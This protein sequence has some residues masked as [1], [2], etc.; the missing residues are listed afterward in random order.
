MRSLTIQWL[1][2]C[3]AA[4]EPAGWLARWNFDPLLLAALAVVSLYGVAKLRG[5]V[6]R[7]RVFGAAVL[8]LVVLFVSPLCALTSALFAARTV[9]H[10]ALV[11]FAAPL[12][13]WALPPRRIPTANL[14]AWTA[15]HAAIFWAWH[16][17]AF[18][19]AA[20]SSDAVYW[21]MQSSL[22]GSAVM[23]WAGVR[24]SAVTSAVAALLANM[25]QMGLLGALLT[26]ASAPLYAPHLATTR[27][28]GFAAIEDQ[29]LAGLVMWAPGAALYLG[30][31]LLVANRWLSAESRLAA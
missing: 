28:W 23:F 6:R 12:L 19:G 5:D 15:G 31:A 2:Y 27:A 3:G 20:L 16:W 30:A 21:V 9:H 17:P 1:P 18:Y 22:L 10:V 14:P 24:Q 7:I 29:Q 26:F 11:A 13:A 4:P 8:V 25:V